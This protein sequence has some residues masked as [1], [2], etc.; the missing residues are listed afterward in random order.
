MDAISCLTFLTANPLPFAQIFF[1]LNLEMR[2]DNNNNNVINK[3]L[4][5]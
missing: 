3:V 2:F 1:H 5:L 4:N